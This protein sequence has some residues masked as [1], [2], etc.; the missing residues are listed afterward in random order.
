MCT[1]LAKFDFLAKHHK[2]SYYLGDEVYPLFSMP[3]IY[4]LILRGIVKNF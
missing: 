1:Y 3:R 4:Q 2:E